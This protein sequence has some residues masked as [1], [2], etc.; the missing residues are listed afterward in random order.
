MIF[1]KVLKYAVVIFSDVS[2]EYAAAIFRVTCFKWMLKWS[3]ARNM[4]V[5]SDC[6]KCSALH[7]YAIRDEG[8]GLSGS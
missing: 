5:I 1:F 8:I 2:D 7:G 3:R 6:L 4:L